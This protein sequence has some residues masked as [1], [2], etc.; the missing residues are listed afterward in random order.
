MKENGDTKL[1][2]DNNFKYNNTYSKVYA[3][4][5]C[6]ARKEPSSIRCRTSTERIE[7]ERTETERYRQCKANDE[8]IGLR[9]RTCQDGILQGERCKTYSKIR[10]RLQTL[11]LFIFYIDLLDSHPHYALYC[12]SDMVQTLINKRLCR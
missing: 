1:P 12:I 7:S 9:I 6:K 8:G 4:N 3:E 11:A 10:V 5:K 2:T